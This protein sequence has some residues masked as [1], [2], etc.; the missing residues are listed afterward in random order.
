MLHGRVSVRTHDY[1][2]LR[3]GD[4]FRLFRRNTARPRQ[5]YLRDRHRS[6]GPGC[7]AIG[8]VWT[9]FG[10]DLRQTRHE[11]RVLREHVRR[12]IHLDTARASF[13]HS[14][15]LSL[16]DRAY[17]IPR[18]LAAFRHHWGRPLFTLSR[19]NR[20]GLLRRS[21]LTRDP[22]DPADPTLFASV[23]ARRSRALPHQ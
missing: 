10:L 17:Y 21:I 16:R 19:G 3:D 9:S 2:D 4:G 7:V 8:R 12:S 14:R 11:Q 6:P 20:V 23:V 22:F 13:L 15:C 5:W 18:V 1:G